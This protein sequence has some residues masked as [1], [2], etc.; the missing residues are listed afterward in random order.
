M[1]FL[2]IRKQNHFLSFK[3]PSL[4]KLS[5]G[6]VLLQMKLKHGAILAQRFLCLFFLNS[7]SSFENILFTFGCAIIQ[8]QRLICWKRT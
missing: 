7:V 1:L 3:Q 2:K 4:T 8:N 5:I 6:Y